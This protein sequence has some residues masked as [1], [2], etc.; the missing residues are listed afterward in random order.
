MPEITPGTVIANRY[1]VGDRLGSGG[2]A[3]VY[4]T[5]D[6]ELGRN[7]ALKVLHRRFSDDPGFV[8]RFRLEAQ[9]AAGLQ[10]P[11]IVSVFD[12]GDWDGTSWIAMEYL[13]GTTLKEVVRQDAPLEPARATRIALQI[14][15]AVAFAHRAGVVHRD[16]KPQ[17]VMIGPDDRAT[18]TDFGIARA[19]AAGVTEAGSILGTAHYISPEQAQGHDA[20][21]QADVYSIGI[22]LYEMLTGRVPFDAESPVAIAMQQVTAEPPPPSATVPGIPTDLEALTLQ[23]LAKD[24]LIRPA[25]ADELVVRLDAISERL[26]VSADPGATVAFGAASVTTAMAAAASSEAPISAGDSPPPEV[27][28][29]NEDLEEGDSSKRKWWIAGGITAALA[30]AGIGL[31]LLVKPAPQITMPL[32]VG[33]DI[34]TATTII[35]NAGFTSAPDIQKVQSNQPKGRV[36][37]QN[38]LANAKV[39]TDAKVVL[40][41]SDGPGDV[42]IP[43]VADLKASEA[44]AKLEKLG[45]KVVVRQKASN[46]V[47]KGNAIGTDPAAGVSVVKGTE[48]T[49]FAS[50]GAAPIDVPDVT[51]QDVAS[52]RSTLQGAGFVVT[53]SKKEVCDQ[54]AGTVISQSPSGGTKAPKG[55][56]VSLLVTADDQCAD[57][58]AVTGQTQADA[59]VTLT[60]AGFKVRTSGVGPNAVGTNPAEGTRALKGSTVTVTLG[61]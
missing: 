23:C 55:S 40:T 53:T 49:L 17:N 36:I 32:V 58:P 9:S 61:T 56:T 21:P 39:G 38:P 12:R 50:S 33:K 18:V 2:M 57:I 10:H 5:H 45:F 29:S 13:P 41:V 25:G 34:Q 47:E 60:D 3:D 30:V 42:Q 26:R 24:P 28:R 22:V 20:G 54:T 7:V 4:L 1:T 27:P 51:Q 52:A 8:D 48:I 16:I 14:S 6:A 44:Q 46:D 59:T 37:K 43:T 11:N 35:S 19:G 31:F 15:Q